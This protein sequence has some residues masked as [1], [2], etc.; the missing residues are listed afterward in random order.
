MSSA[1]TRLYG[2]HNHPPRSD[3]VEVTSP[4]EHIANLLGLT[5]VRKYPFRMSKECMYDLS[6]TDPQCAGC[7]HG[8]QYDPN[9]P[10]A[11]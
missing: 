11:T 5:L 9:K 6:K 3:Y 7:K 4:Y 2:C 1:Q 8:E 10:S